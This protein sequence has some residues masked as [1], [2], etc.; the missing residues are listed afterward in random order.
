M[1]DE[2]GKLEE[3]EWKRYVDEQTRMDE[4]CKM[5]SDLENKIRDLEQNLKE[6][7]AFFS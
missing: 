1:K 3:N 6:K 2:K 7:Q 5:R 4:E